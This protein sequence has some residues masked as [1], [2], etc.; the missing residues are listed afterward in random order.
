MSQVHLMENHVLRVGYGSCALPSRGARNESD[1]SEVQWLSHRAP[2][3][4][5]LWICLM[6]MV[7]NLPVRPCCGNR[8]PQYHGRAD[9]LFAL[10]V[11]AFSGL[12]DET[13]DHG[14]AKAAQSHRLRYKDCAAISIQRRCRDLNQDCPGHERHQMTTP[15][16]LG[17]MN[18]SR[19]RRNWTTS[20]PVMT[21]R[22]RPSQHC[23]DRAQPLQDAARALPSASP[24]RRR[25]VRAQRP[26][27]ALQPRQA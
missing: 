2:S 24:M 21:G 1:A 23:E 22:R 4:L 11:K 19:A 8:Q 15:L 20:A 5:S 12:L 18:L 9:A 14:Q 25:M 13:H 10:N 6:P 27:W 3:R 16:E 7:L 26:H 17:R